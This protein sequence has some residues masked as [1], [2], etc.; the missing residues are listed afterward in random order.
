MRVSV[1]ASVA[2]MGPGFDVLAMAVDLWL[3]VE[4]EEADEPE[5]EFEGEAAEQ[6]QNEPNP[7]STLAM[8]GG[9]RN[10]IPVGVGRGSSAAARVAAAALQGSEDPIR[11]ACRQE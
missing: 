6:L 9:V 11:D 3:E 7:L 5:W 8:R 4:A 1:P 2:N 10:A